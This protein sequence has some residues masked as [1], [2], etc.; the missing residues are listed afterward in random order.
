MRNA[1]LLISLPALA[2]LGACHSGQCCDDEGSESARATLLT[3]AKAAYFAGWSKAAGQN[4]TMDN[5][6]KVYDTGEDFLAF[7]GMSEK[8]TVLSGWKVYSDTW[9]PGMN[10]FTT[11][12]VTEAKSLRTWMEDDLAVTASIAH[13]HG[14]MPNGGVLDAQGHLTLVFEFDDGAWRIVHEHMSLPVKE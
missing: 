7:D 13:I 2:L 6:G 3:N 11:A 10:G 1:A 4:F 5:L 14:T 12:S 8:K 9:G